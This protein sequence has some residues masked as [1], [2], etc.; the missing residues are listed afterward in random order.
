MKN[1]ICRPCATYCAAMLISLTLY[2]VM[3]VL[4]L[5]WLKAGVEGPWKY[6]V[7]VLPVPQ[8]VAMDVGQPGA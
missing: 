8:K 4:S 7:A 2:T 1:W 3:L 6:V 5:T